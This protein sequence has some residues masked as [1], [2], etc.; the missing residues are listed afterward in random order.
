M[1]ANNSAQTHKSPLNST[2]EML[3]ELSSLRDFQKFSIQHQNEFINTHLPAHLLKL[4][5]QKNISKAQVIHQANLDRVYGY[6]IF[7][8]TRTPTREKLLQ[9]AF[10]F[11]LSLEETQEILKIAGVAPL[12]AKIKREAAIIFCL[13]KK[14]SLD[15]AQ[16]FLFQADLRVIND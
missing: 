13:N 16:E 14:Y 3:N 11:R 1:T 7:N 2:E 12:Y 6:Q 8:G 9:L 15:E 5:Q 10:G 4:L